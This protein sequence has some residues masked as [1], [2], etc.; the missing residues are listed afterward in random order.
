[1]SS[2]DELFPA[3]LVNAKKEKVTRDTL[4]GKKVGVYFSA[5]WC[6]PCRGFTPTLVEFYEEL[7]SQGK[8]FEIVFVS[9]DRSEQDMFGYMTEANMPWLAV[10]Y[11]DEHVAKLKQKYGISG[12]PTLVILNQDGEIIT[13]DGRG[14]VA[15]KGPRAFE[16]W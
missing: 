9:S 13:K 10:P 8:D 2:F 1:M 7:K 12:I 16:S 5:H 15:T 14:Q 3:E 6:P 11:G 4:H